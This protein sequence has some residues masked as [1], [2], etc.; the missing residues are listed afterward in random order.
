[1]AAVADKRP[2]ILV[3]LYWGIAVGLLAAVVGAWLVIQA[4]VP[5]EDILRGV[6]IPFFDTIKPVPF[7]VGIVGALL[8]LGSIAGVFAGRARH[9]W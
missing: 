6:P 3:A 2:R 1:M 7:F 5:P 8:A 4:Y 9:L